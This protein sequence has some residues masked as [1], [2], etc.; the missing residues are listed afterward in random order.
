[1]KRICVYCGSSS[2]ARPVFAESA[3]ALGRAL[4][5]RGLGLVYG[6]AD[7][8]LMGVIADTVL[9][10]G[11]EVIGVIPHGLLELE[12]AHPE[13]TELVVV[14]TLHERKARMLSLCDALVTLPGGHGAHD[15]LFE[16]LTWLQLGIHDKPV[17]LLNVEGFYDGLVAH[18]D[19]AS[20]EGFI[21]PEHR[22][23]LLVDDD[24]QRLLDRCGRF[25]PPPRPPW[26]SGA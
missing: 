6:G 5:E 16:A 13:L 24:P 10:A 2:G 8:G 21:R 20:T 26:R 14:D 7:C 4:A 23:L 25:R 3:A 12:A 1:M 18:L 22:A 9:A 11:G 15:E 17:G 19:R